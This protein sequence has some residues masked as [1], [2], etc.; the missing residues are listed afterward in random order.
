MTTAGKLVDDDD[1]PV[2]DDI[3]FVAVE[4]FVRLERLLDM[5]VER[6]VVDIAQVIDIEE[7]L[8]LCRALFGD[9]YAAVLAVDDVIPISVLGAFGNVVVVAVLGLGFLFGGLFFG[10][11]PFLLV[12]ILF[13]L[14][15]LVV[16][17][18]GERAH[19]AVYP[20]VQFAGLVPFARNDERGARFVDENGVDLVDDGEIQFAL[21]HL[22]RSVFKLSRK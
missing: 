20:L 13:A 10:F 17:S 8:G 1:F 7:T 14:F 3:V 18:A 19:K 22:L 15:A 12:F 5:V 9:L 4:K 16:E 6:R 11:L 21:D 2:V